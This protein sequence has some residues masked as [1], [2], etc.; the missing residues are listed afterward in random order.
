MSDT[1]PRTLF[2]RFERY[3]NRNGPIH[4]VLGTRCHLWTGGTTTGGRYGQFYVGRINGKKTHRNS[5]RVALEMHSGP[6]SVGINACHR[7]DV[8]L[9]CNPRHLVAGTQLFNIQDAWKKGRITK[10]Q[11]I[12]AN[13]A[14]VAGQLAK[15]HCKN[16]HEFTPKT[17]RL[18]RGARICKICK[19]KQQQDFNDRRQR[20]TTAER[21]IE[22]H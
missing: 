18:W 6:L 20:E 21:S 10:S 11:M 22:G 7:C 17:T 8:T 5:H 14:R 16:G 3:V 19:R 9:C 15:T 13:A 2:E 1:I 4:P 12:A